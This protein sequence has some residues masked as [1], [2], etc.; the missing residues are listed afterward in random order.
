MDNTYLRLIF[1]FV[2]A[3]LLSLAT[4]P[5]VR[6]VA[7][8]I[9]AVDEPRGERHKHKR[10]VATAG[11][12]AIFYSFLITVLCFLNISHA[13]RGLL[14]GG[15]IITALGLIDDISGIKY[16]IKFIVQILVALLVVYH[17][18][19]IEK[20]NIPFIGMQLIFGDYATPVTVLWIVAITNSINLLDGLD[21]LAA[22][23]STISAITLV[24]TAILMSDPVIAILAVILAGAGSG[25]LPFN[26]YPAKM[27]LG[28]T[29]ST[30]LGFNLACISIMGLFKLYAVMSFSVPLL[31]LCL[32]LLDTTIAFTRRIL[33]GKSP[34]KADRG[35]IHHKLVDKGLS[36]KMAVFTLYTI[37]ALLSLSSIVMMLGGQSGQWRALT[38]IIAVLF[39]VIV[40][41][42]FMPDM[43]K[44]TRDLYGKP[45][46]ENK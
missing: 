17:G 11:G 13:I 2:I 41:Y 39:I 25:F 27:F 37:S 40:G 16:Y 7:I 24:V 28:D 15:I 33:K 45:K 4:S 19:K 20:L 10:V 3:F 36:Q 42:Y 46:E 9:G 21:G 18:I 31:I 6:I 12:I 35:H 8:K 26:K 23:I 14:I 22:G 5:I 30:F 44:H 1:A 29:G 32:P 34:F 38:L 43:M